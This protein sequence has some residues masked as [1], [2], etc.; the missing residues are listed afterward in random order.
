MTNNPIVEVYKN[1]NFEGDLL[2]NIAEEVALFV[3]FVFFVFTRSANSRIIIILLIIMILLKTFLS[4]KYRR[5]YLH[6]ATLG[7]II[8]QILILILKMYFLFI[9]RDCDIACIEENK[10]LFQ[11][12][13][14]F[15]IQ[16]D[17]IDILRT[18]I[19]EI[20][21]LIITSIL[22]RFQRN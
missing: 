16:G 7:V 6:V 1:I 2:S 11:R 8:A 22:F 9:T 3:L 21:S 10:I 5:R 20:S 17:K 4:H 18:L 13:G 19:F 14:L 12:I 15:F